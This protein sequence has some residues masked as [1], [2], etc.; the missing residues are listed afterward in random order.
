VFTLTGTAAAVEIVDLD[1]TAPPVQ[2]LLG[3]AEAGLRIQPLS[4]SDQRPSGAPSGTA[5]ARSS[6]R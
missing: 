2:V 3:L 4:G 1:P 6:S 5:P